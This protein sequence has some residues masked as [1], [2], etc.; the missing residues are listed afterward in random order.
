M[1]PNRMCAPTR[2]PQAPAH[3][4]AFT[5]AAVQE[6]F[7]FKVA[8]LFSEVGLAFRHMQFKASVGHTGIGADICCWPY[9]HVRHGA[10]L[11]DPS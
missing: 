5:E 6:S 4:F 2:V 7:G 9:R 8:D 11:A 3:A 1:R 10:R